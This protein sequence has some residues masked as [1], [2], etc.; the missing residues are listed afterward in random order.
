MYAP[1]GA[2]WNF[3]MFGNGKGKFVPCSGVSGIMDLF[4]LE[5]RIAD[6]TTGNRRE[7]RGIAV[8]RE[9]LPHQGKRDPSIAQSVYPSAPAIPG[10]LEILMRPSER[11]SPLPS[12]HP[13]VTWLLC[14]RRRQN[15]NYDPS[16]YN[17]SSQSCSRTASVYIA[18]AIAYWERRSWIP[19]FD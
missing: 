14:P 12:R 9:L 8:P 5:F 3:I 10:F 11:L 6:V 15:V 1:N 4:N 7:G 19:L 18:D 16:S 17:C 2:G 13:K